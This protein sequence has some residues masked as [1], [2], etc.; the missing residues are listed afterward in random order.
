M[1]YYKHIYFRISDYQIPFELINIIPK[2]I[3]NLVYSLCLN[4][5]FNKIYIIFK[6]KME[7]LCTILNS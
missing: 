4:K 5:S 3:Y 1:V 6:K 7:S 2:F